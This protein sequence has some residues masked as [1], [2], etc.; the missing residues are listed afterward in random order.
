MQCVVGI[1]RAAEETESK[2]LL[3][4]DQQEP[5]TEEI[6][7][8]VIT[9][10]LHTVTLVLHNIFYYSL[11]LFWNSTIFTGFKTVC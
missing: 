2:G 9:F 8:V 7:T 1:N 5:N 10:N 3:P 11:M 6:I 4:F